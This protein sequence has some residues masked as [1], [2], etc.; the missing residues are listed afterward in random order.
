[1][2]TDTVTSYVQD[3]QYRDNPV[4]S[5]APKLTKGNK[6]FS[7]KSK[8]KLKM[9]IN[10]VKKIIKM[11]CK[12]KLANLHRGNREDIN[13]NEKYKTKELNKINLVLMYLIKW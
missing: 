9:S 3:L 11:E 5:G 8:I 4:Y 6:M 12:T 13:D 10:N 1:M 7:D 2:V